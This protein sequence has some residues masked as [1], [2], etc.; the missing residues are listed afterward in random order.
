MAEPAAHEAESMRTDLG[1]VVGYQVRPRKRAKVKRELTLT[2]L[3][4]AI[5][6]ID[7][8]VSLRR[9]CVDTSDICG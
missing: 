3:S 8:V 2:M 4:K 5:M 1:S 6:W 7:V 9:E